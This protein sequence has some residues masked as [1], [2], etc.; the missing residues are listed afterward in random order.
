MP[1]PKLGFLIHARVDHRAR[2]YQV[3][4]GLGAGIGGVRQIAIEKPV[5]WVSLYPGAQISV[6][7]TIL[8][9]SFVPTDLSSANIVLPALFSVFECYSL[10]KRCCFQTFSWRDSF[11]VLSM[12]SL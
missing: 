3:D 6:M 1:S 4:R 7:R 11:P 9:I 5:T 2:V 10:R 12:F 8:L